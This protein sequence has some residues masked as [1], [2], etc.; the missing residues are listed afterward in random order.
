MRRR[1]WI[2][3]AFMGLVGCSSEP[4]KPGAGPKK[5]PLPRSRP[6]RRSPKGPKGPKTMGNLLLESYIEDLK[7]GTTDKQITAA[8]ELGNMGTVAIA[9]L[10]DLESLTTNPN[11]RLRTAAQKAI[12]AIQKKPGRKN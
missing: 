4:K 6:P 8:T 7:T 3:T 11:A 1:V 2:I 5:K 12:Q 10:P 9:A